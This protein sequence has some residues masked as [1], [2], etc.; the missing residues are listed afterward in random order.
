[1]ERRIQKELKRLEYEY[2]WEPP[3]LT[4][5]FIAPQDSI[6]KGLQFESTFDLSNYPFSLKLI[7]VINT[8]TDQIIDFPSNIF[9][10]ILN[11]EY[12]GDTWSPQNNLQEVIDTFIEIINIPHKHIDTWENINNECF[13]QHTRIGKGGELQE[14]EPLHLIDKYYNYIL[15]SSLIQHKKEQKINILCLYSGSGYRETYFIKKLMKDLNIQVGTIYFLDEVYDSKLVVYQPAYIYSLLCLKNDPHIDNIVLLENY[16]KMDDINDLD[17]IVEI[18]PFQELDKPSD[19]DLFENIQK[20][21]VLYN[22]HP[23]IFPS[24]TNLN[25]FNNIEELQQ[26]HPKEYEMWYYNKGPGV[27]EL[28]TSLIQHNPESVFINILEKEGE[29]TCQ[30]ILSKDILKKKHTSI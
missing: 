25:Q 30:V 21:K 20:D 2:K 6:Y 8:E 4:I 10:D 3:L 9:I 5:I 12:L 29:N 15:E 17:L 13:K 16:S 18:Q 11:K 22:T 26:Q 28:F 14:T 19:M 23:Y 7:N 27:Q 1:M 24:L